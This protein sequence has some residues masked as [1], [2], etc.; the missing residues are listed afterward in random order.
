MLKFQPRLYQQAIFNTTASKNTLV[1]LPTGLGKTNIFL[2]LTIHRLRLYPKSKIVMLAPTK[3]LAHQHL[4][5]AQKYLDLPPETF[6][7]LTGEITPKQ[8]RE[9]WLKS[10]VLFSTPQTV[11]NDLISGRVN[12]KDV[13]LICF[14]ESHRATGDYAY[15]WI[16]K[17][18]IQQ[19]TYPRILGL[20]AS[21]GAD[22]E[23]VTEI[24]DNLYIEDVEVRSDDDPDV[25]PYIKEV[26][27]E[28]IEVEIPDEFKKILKFFN[29]AIKKKSNEIKILLKEDIN[30]RSKKEIL[31]FQ[32]DLHTRIKS[33]AAM[34]P[35][36]A[37]SRLSEII[38][39]QHASELLETQGITAIHKY[40]SKLKK[41]AK[42]TRVKATI[43]LVRD[44][45]FRSAFYLVD[46][47]YENDI[48]HPKLL[49][50]VSLIKKEV[51]ENKKAIIFN[52][53]RDSG[54][55]LEETL[56]EIPGI[57][58]Q[59]FVGQMKK[60]GIGLSQKNQKLMLKDFSEGK[61]NV[62]I[63]TSIGEE[64]LDIPKVDLV[65]FYE[66]V[67]SAIRSIQRRGRTGRHES[68]KVIILIAKGTR[69]EA[70]RWVAVH[71]ERRMHKLLKDIKKKLIIKKPDPKQSS[72]MSFTEKTDKNVKIYADFREKNSQVMKTM[73]DLGTDL[74]LKKLEMGDYLCSQDVVI[75]LKSREDFVNSII[76]RR[77]LQQ[78]K[79][80][81]ENY[82]K[83]MVVVYG[84]DNF[85][86]M[87]MIN[88]SS[89]YGMI[90]T[91]AIKFNVPV[92]SVLTPREAAKLIFNIAKLEQSEGG[93]EISLHYR[94]PLT[95]NELQEYIVSAL[96]GVGIKLAK[97][98]LAKF[99]TIKAISNAKIEELMEVKLVGKIKAQRILEIMNNVYD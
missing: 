31:M 22:I 49:K 16:A 54:R 34:E 10:R 8:R 73:H 13:S 64:G 15:V 72:L 50:L 29:D 67:P 83:P 5:N 17:K 87:R 35:M 26:E 12:L 86:N 38:K 79:S 39:L 48:E 65:V 78:V 89:V 24:S 76:D 61:F 99:K 7:V 46:K 2:M 81:K 97:P 66:P 93:D 21:P 56:K 63:S 85:S 95:T 27:I 9:V 32:R 69:D 82:E 36:V 74:E 80:L 59:L 23:K 96:P 3:P 43:N 44:V 94:K 60:D 90:S 92:I 47:L 55:K 62:L 52:H 68:G 19:A 1:V 11:E 37:I 30:L 41:E 28:K 6:G 57:S 70:Y 14:D 45:D 4:I 18:Y 42:S 77:L 58:P 91:I 33:E 25:M 98:L 88:E 75:E 20:T 53:F 71:K 51:T 40:M 84:T